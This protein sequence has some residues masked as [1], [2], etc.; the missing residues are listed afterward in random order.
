MDHK[1]TD[2]MKKIEIKEKELE[3]KEA[4][5]EEAAAGGKCIFRVGGGVRG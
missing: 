5:V 4:K 3:T 2:K 1:V